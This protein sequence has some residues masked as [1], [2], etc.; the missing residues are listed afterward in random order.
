MTGKF[1]YVIDVSIP[2]GAICV[3]THGE[4][5][6]AWINCI[7]SVPVAHVIKYSVQPS[8]S[9]VGT[10]CSTAG[11][12]R[13]KTNH[14]SRAHQRPIRFNQ[15]DIYSPWPTGRHFSLARDFADLFLFEFYQWPVGMIGSR[16]NIYQANLDHIRSKASA[17]LANIQSTR[18]Q[19]LA[20]AAR[21]D[22]A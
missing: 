6:E 2:L 3:G 8:I 18:L 15:I 19:G 10:G 14:S 12:F 13:S 20:T 22:Q 17:A 4:N 16:A 5:T 7:V 21:C 11:Y 9:C 1:S